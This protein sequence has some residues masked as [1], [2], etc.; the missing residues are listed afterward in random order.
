MEVM[1]GGC[2]R[3]DVG[4]EALS[5][6][7]PDISLLFVGVNLVIKVGVRNMDFFGIYSNDGTVFFV[8]FANFEDIL[9][10]MN[11]VVE[12]FVPITRI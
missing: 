2:Y 9:A 1:I 3:G 10:T 7:V 5:L 12:E 6:P 8:Q 11:A 4:P